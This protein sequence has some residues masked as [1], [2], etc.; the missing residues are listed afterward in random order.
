[1]DTRCLP[2][3]APF[4]WSWEHL[5]QCGGGQGRTVHGVESGG[6]SSRLRSLDS[7]HRDQGVTADKFS[8]AYQLCNLRQV[9]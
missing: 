4:A 5:K 6:A 2:V 1:M 3:A 9:T 8:A 7:I